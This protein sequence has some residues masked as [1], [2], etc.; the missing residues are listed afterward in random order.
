[1]AAVDLE[2]LAAAVAVRLLALSPRRGAT[3]V[4][5]CLQPQSLPESAWHP[6]RIPISS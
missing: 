2:Q 6:Y 1:M 4:P 5:M 3:V